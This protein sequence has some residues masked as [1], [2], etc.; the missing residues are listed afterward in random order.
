MTK[1]PSKKKVT[2]KKTTT[3]KIKKPLA[4]KPQRNK[5]TQKELLEFPCDFTI[6]VVGRS[7]DNFRAHIELIVR[8]RFPKIKDSAFSQRLSREANY[9]ALTIVVH[10]KNRAELDSLYEELSASPKVI[11]AL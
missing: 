11:M 3:T 10:V 5:T 2:P 9:L 7:D 4:K 8:K 1:K 6:K